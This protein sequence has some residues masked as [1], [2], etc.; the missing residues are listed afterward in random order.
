MDIGSFTS[1][2]AKPELKA[3]LSKWKGILLLFFVVLMSFWSIG[4]SLGSEQYLKSKMDS[5]FVKFLGID[6][7][8]TKAQNKDFVD[9]LTLKL[10]RPD[11]KEKYYIS[12][13]GFVSYWTPNFSSKENKSILAKVRA[14][15]TDNDLYRFIFDNNLIVSPRAKSLETA[16]WSMIVTTRYLKK[17]GYREGEYPAYLNYVIGFLRGDSKMPI[18]IA[19]VVSQLP[20]ECD[21]FVTWKLYEAFEG[22]YGDSN[23]LY[24]DQLVYQSQQRFFIP[25]ETEESLRTKLNMKD[26]F[27]IL[28]Q[29]E[30]FAEGVLIESLG[31]TDL[32]ERLSQ[33]RKDFG[34]GVIQVYN[35]DAVG[36][37]VETKRR[38]TY[39]NLIIEFDDLNKINEFEAFMLTEPIG[40]TID[41]NVIEARNNFLLF[42]KISRV[43]SSVLSLFSIAFIITFLTR[44]ITEHIDR[45]AKNLGTLKAF[46]LSNKS[47]AWTYSGISGVLVLA[48]FI[49]ALFIAW[50]I[51]IPLTNLLLNTIGIELT[52]GDHMF[53]LEVDVLMLIYFVV[54]P[55]GLIT[56][57]LYFK[58]RKQT[59]G[60]L[61][62]ER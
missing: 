3:I 20:N 39:D 49:S 10:E 24:P 5:P 13:H 51:G 52:N 26:S 14:I 32:P 36:Y 59:P 17:L 43:L 22:R 38:I 16:Q 33:L 46:G 37:S 44:T 23:P 61:I 62:Y 55:I 2:F 54:I 56:S 12:K 4:F 47:I 31:T 53:N 9:T 40:L 11:I 15:D 18:P 35:F 21:I 1:V 60:D 57:V 27:H 45:N 29:E 42:S 6:L 50:V 58:I 41:M 8:Y 30:S 28:K 25:D 34:N 7:P 19:A 48:I